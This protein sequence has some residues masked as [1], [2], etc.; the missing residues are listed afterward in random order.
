MFWKTTFGLFL[1]RMF[2]NVVAQAS[3]VLYTD[4]MNHH[5]NWGAVGYAAAVQA[6]YVVITTTRDYADPSIA[7]KIKVDFQ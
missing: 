2:Y 4:L 5:V 3:L 1:K 7:N 6:L